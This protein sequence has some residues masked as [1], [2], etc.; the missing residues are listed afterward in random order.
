MPRIEP[1]HAAPRGLHA[2]MPPPRPSPPE[3]KAAPSGRPGLQS[4]LGDWLAGIAGRV[5]DAAEALGPAR[6]GGRVHEFADLVA[7]ARQP[8]QI[9]SALVALAGELADASRVELVVD[10]DEA[11]HPEPRRIAVWPEAAGAMTAEE[12]EA[13]GYPLCLG[14]WCGDHFQMT[15]QLYARPGRGGRWPQR[16]VRRLTTLCA[17]AA[18][19]ERGLHAGRRARPETPAEASAAVRD[20][21]FLNAILPYALSQA[22][23]HREPLTVFCVEVVG[24][25]ALRRSLGR[26]AADAA[27]GRVAE[28]VARTLRGS[29][30]VARLDDDRMVVVLPN[31]GSADAR[32]VAEVVRAATPA[33]CLPSAGADGLSASIGVSCFPDDADDMAGILS[34]AD[35]AV[36]RARALGP[37]QVAAFSIPPSP[38]VPTV[39][40]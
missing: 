3:E 14:L 12:V 16:V 22:R 37:N 1:K 19:A 10:R 25:P 39:R 17:M 28:A 32:T 31:T 26:E 40:R 27:V 29:D 6:G 15:L 4:R 18:A 9:E 13:L 35:E 34:A 20:A 30:V 36:G 33:A 38:V 7:L 2:T 11:S 8:E 24:L 23:R 21:T 5:R